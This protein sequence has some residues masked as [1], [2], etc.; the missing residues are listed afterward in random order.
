M[1]RAYAWGV[2]AVITAMVLG[3]GCTEGLWPAS[4]IESDAMNERL[5]DALA[6]LIEYLGRLD[7]ADTHAAATL[8]AKFPVDSQIGR[9]SC[10]RV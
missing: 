8:N 5:S 10:E 9:A 1:S 2:L 7:P 3:A 6:P 4:L